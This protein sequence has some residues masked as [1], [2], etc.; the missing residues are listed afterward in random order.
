MEEGERGRGREREER[1]QTS[2]VASFDIL[3]S[4]DPKKETGG[5]SVFASAQTDVR[6]EKEQILGVIFIRGNKASYSG[7]S[8]G[9]T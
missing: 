5:D 1:N 9:T 6:E 7:K 4:E 2:G 8:E 3:G